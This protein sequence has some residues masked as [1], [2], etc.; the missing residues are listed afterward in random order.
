MNLRPPFT[1]VLVL[2][3]LASAGGLHAVSAAREWNELLLSAIRQTIP[4]PPQHAR[5]LFHDFHD[6]HVGS[7]AGQSAFA[8]A[9]QYWSGTIFSQSLSPADS[10]LRIGAAHGAELKGPHFGKSQRGYRTS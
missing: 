2:A 3:F 5:N 10:R 8:L 7:Q 6:R 1:G 4:N 9:E